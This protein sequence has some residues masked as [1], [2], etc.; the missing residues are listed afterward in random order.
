MGNSKMKKSLIFIIAI[1]ALLCNCGSRKE[2]V[3]LTSPADSVMKVTE[4]EVTETEV[5]ETE[6]SASLAMGATKA[7]EYYEQEQ[8]LAEAYSNENSEHRLGGR[9]VKRNGDYL[10]ITMYLKAENGEV[11]G[12][13]FYHG[14][15]EK[16]DILLK[17]RVAGD[18]LMLT[19]YDAQDR[20]TGSFTGSVWGGDTFEGEWT[21]PDKKRSLFFKLFYDDRDYKQ[22]KIIG[23]KADEFSEPAGKEQNL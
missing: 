6:D 1:S 10:L 2:S 11:S 13:Y 19:E 14:N 7:D 15:P 12:K 21:S 5:T 8:Q 3:T 17:G 18:S 20:I 22:R 9:M 4:T 23:L 16:E